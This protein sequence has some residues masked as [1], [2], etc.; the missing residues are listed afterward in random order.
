MLKRLNARF[1]QGAEDIDELNKYGYVPL[2]E[3]IDNPTLNWDKIV[4][5]KRKYEF[6]GEHHC[7]LC[8]KKI[9]S[10]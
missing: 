5:M 1:T 4:K 3:E 8:P 7:K 9:I 2:Q 6:E 10:S